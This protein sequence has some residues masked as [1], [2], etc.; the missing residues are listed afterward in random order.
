[1]TRTHRA[2]I[3]M[4]SLVLAAALG[5]A[6]LLPQAGDAAAPR[7]PRELGHSQRNPDPTCVSKPGR[8]LGYGSVTGF[9]TRIDGKKRPFVAPGDGKIVAWSVQLGG[10]PSRKGNP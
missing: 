10:P 3:V 1:M 4:A 2:P 5:L 6:V 8:C 9:M 7:Q